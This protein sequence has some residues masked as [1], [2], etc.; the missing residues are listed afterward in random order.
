[1]CLSKDCKLLKDVGL[2]SY[3][4]SVVPYFSILFLKTNMVGQWKT[5]WS[6]ARIE[7]D[8]LFRRLS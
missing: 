8:C 3:M 6:C 7:K 5:D 1:M 2:G 4:G